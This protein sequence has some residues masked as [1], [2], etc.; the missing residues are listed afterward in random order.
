MKNT[1]QVP[2]IHRKPDTVISERWEAETGVLR[3]VSPAF[4]GINKVESKN[5]HSRLSSDCHT[6]AT[7]PIHPHALSYIHTQ[8]FFYRGGGGGNSW[9]S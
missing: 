2:R 6:Y 5:Q 4:S 7:A 9:S 1:V 3:Q 8:T